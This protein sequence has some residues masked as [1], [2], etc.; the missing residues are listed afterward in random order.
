[1]SGLPRSFLTAGARG[2]VGTLWP[3]EDLYES[4][5]SVEFYRRFIVS[6][7]AEL[8]LAATQ[9]AWLSPRAGE[10]ER[11]HQQRLATAWAHVF[12]ARPESR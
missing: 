9:R 5:F 1:M 6:R 3:V 12:Y 8:A 7:D 10:K 4:Q 11:E 2:V